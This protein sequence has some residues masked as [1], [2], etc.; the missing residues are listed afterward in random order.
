MRFREGLES[1]AKRLNDL[2]NA[3]TVVA[4]MPTEPAPTESQDR[5]DDLL[6]ETRNA[7]IVRR[8]FALALR[9]ALTDSMDPHRIRRARGDE[10]GEAFRK[11]VDA[12]AR[13][14]VEEARK[15]LGEG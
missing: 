7:A 9:S 3:K 5:I 4:P 2:Q 8:V 12:E 1:V 10:I 15:E 13:R 11:D 6:E 14:Y